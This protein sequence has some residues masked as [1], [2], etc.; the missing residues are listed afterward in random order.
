[1]RDTG[2]R[3][4]RRRR[5]LGCAACS[6]ASCSRRCR[7]CLRSRRDWGQLR[8]AEADRR[9]LHRLLY[10]RARHLLCRWR[11]RG[12]IG[13]DSRRHHGHRI[14][15]RE[16]LIP[17]LR[18]WV[19]RAAACCGVGDRV[20]HRAADIGDV[21]VAEIIPVTAVA[22]PIDLAGAERE[23]ADRRPDIGNVPVTDAG[24][25]NKGDQRRR[26]DRLRH[27]FAGDPRP[28]VLDHGPTAVMERR[29][30]PGLVIDPAPAPRIEPDPVA[31]AVRRPAG[32]DPFRKPYLAILRH[33]APAAV[34]VELLI[35]GHLRRDAIGRGELPLVIVARA[36]P[37][38]E[39]VRA[40]LL[41][42]GQRLGAADHRGIA[43]LDRNI[44]G[45]ADKPGAAFE[46]RDSLRLALGAGIDVVGSGLQDP[47]RAARQID[48]D[49]LA[50][51]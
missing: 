35:P 39:L 48:L 14:T 25:A 46:Y 51:E 44:E 33:G 11:D 1:M 28:L 4:C 50:L 38:C 3:R 36:A 47:N 8:R 16:A 32:R 21:D 34:L 45:A 13:E 22:R 40:R 6:R 7:R 5:S 10:D 29:E 30:P 18:R 24:I 41:G 20:D 15:V 12:G 43:G 9:L 42:R 23:P 27:E 31:L 37:F 19:G 49:A 26:I 17:D 2:R